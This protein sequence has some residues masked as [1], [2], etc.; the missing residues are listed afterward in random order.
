MISPMKRME[1][2]KK[3]SRRERILT[4]PILPLLIKTAIPTIIGMLINM[5]YNL[6]DT[7]FIGQLNN[8]SMTAAIGIV[9]SFVSFIQAIGFWFGYGSGNS[10][11]RKLGEKED[12]EA[13]ILSSSGIVLALGAGIV[14]MVLLSFFVEPLASLLGGNA[15]AQLLSFTTEYLRIIIFSIPFSLF[16]LTVY[17]QLRLCG[18]VKDGMIGLLVGMLSNM[19]LDPILIFGFKMGFIGAGWATL[20]GQVIGSITLFIL[21]RT[22][23]NIPVSLRAARFTKDRIYHVLAGGAPN[24][25]RQGITSIAS[26]LL[27]IVAARYGESTIAALTVSSRI[28]ALAYMVMIGWGQGFQ[29][30][31]AMNYGAKQYDRV[32]HALK[33]TLSIGTIFLIFATA[34]LAVFASSVTAV[35]S[36]DPEV[37]RLEHRF[38]ASS[39]LLYHLWDFMLSAVCTCRTSGNTPVLYGF[40]LHGRASSTFRCC[41]FCLPSAVSWDYSGYSLRQISCPLFLQVSFCGVI[42]YIQ[43]RVTAPE[44]SSCCYS[45]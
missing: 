5:I 41:S 20:A 12:E 34:L 25:S 36:R 14:L 18:N 28:A 43:K 38:C 37:I 24:F 30:I 21:S 39:V 3:K 9:F 8:K 45:F 1:T 33:L 7:F 10:M 11:S 27:N 6:T 40:P 16:A 44:I 26:V 15:S 13:K 19:I 32:K 22:H 2:E 31:C 17:N 29:P 23:G 42:T 4:E 35:L